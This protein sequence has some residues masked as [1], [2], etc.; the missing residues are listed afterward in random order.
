MRVRPI[1]LVLFLVLVLVTGYAVWWHRMA[2]RLLTLLDH[3]TDLARAAG[4]TITYQPPTLGGFPLGIAITA[5][6]VKVEKPNG[7]SWTADTVKASA[8]VWRLDDVVLTLAK[9]GH[10]TLPHEG[11]RPG[12]DATAA[13]AGARVALDLATGILRSM[14]VDLSHA[15]LT[16][17]ALPVPEGTA[18]GA[19]PPASLMPAG[20]YPLESFSITVERPATPPTDH[21]GTGL[22]LHLDVAGM[23]VP[24]VRSL[25]PTLQRLVLAARVQGPLPAAPTVDAVTPWSKDGG[26]VEVDSL[27]LDWG[28][29]H[30]VANATLALD[31]NLQ[32]QGS[33][34][35]E[36]SG[37]DSLVDALKDGGTLHPNQAAL[38]RAGLALLAK[39]SANGGA[40]SLKLPITMQNH[41]LQI[42]P[43]AVGHYPD[44]VWH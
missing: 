28:D 34:S 12:L 31:D 23:T 20:A 26:T 30:L 43:L 4:A 44:I 25:G 8:P 10:A 2:T 3:N 1:T 5:N 41:K 9:G 18:E 36:L 22:I 33:G 37:L 14:R 42:G 11:A 19:P 15:V 6:Q 16:V 35:A 24:P 39:P 7:L 40:P 13:I 29:L 17:A 21:T 27:K 38:V 32:P